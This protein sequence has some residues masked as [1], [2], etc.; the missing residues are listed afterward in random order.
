[1][2]GRFE[3]SVICCG[4]TFK[5]LE[6]LMTRYFFDL[7]AR[8]TIEHDYKGRYLP[9]LYEAQQ[10]AELIAMDLSCTRVDGASPMEVQIR[11]AKG[12]LLISVAVQ[13]PDAIAA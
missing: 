1:L 11:D 12:C 4:Y 8:N 9:S 3:K 10:M 6:V 2:I 5:K 7:K 13:L